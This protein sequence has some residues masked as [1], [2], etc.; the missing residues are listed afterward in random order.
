MELC[1]VVRLT[2]LTECT[3]ELNALPISQVNQAETC[4]WSSV[5]QGWQLPGQN[6]NAEQLV[7]SAR[8][9]KPGGMRR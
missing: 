4:V 3:T 7:D 1:C 9:A 2:R 8:R 5:R 6:E